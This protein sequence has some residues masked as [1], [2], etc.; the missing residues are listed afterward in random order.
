MK[1]DKAMRRRVVCLDVFRE[2]AHGWKASG[3]GQMKDTFELAV[4]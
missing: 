4:V 1:K 2:G 3:T